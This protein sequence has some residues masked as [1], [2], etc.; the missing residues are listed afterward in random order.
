MTSTSV[1]EGR[2]VLAE[3]RARAKKEAAAE[4]SNIIALKPP[5]AGHDVL[6]AEQEE[7][8]PEWGEVEKAANAPGLEIQCLDGVKAKPIDWLW[9]NRIPVGKVSTLAGD[10]GQ[11]KST[12]LCDVMARTTGGS[13]W[14]D[15]AAG[16]KPASVMIL[17][18]EDGVEDTLVPRLMAAGADL[19]RVFVI[20]S[21]REQRDGDL[22]RRQFNLQA[23]LA[24]LD[25]EIINRGDI[26]LVVIDP[27]TS[28]LGQ[29]DSHKNAEVRAVV[30][31][32]GDLADRRK[33]AIL[34]NNHFSKGAGN[35]NS[36][37]IGSVAFVNQARAAFIVAPDAENDGRYFFMPSK[38][39][40]GPKG[41][42]LSY[43]IES[44]VVD[45]D[46]LTSRIAWESTPVTSTADQ[47][48][49]ALVGGDE[50]RNAR[51]EAE[52]FLRD[53]LADGPV[54]QKEMKA[55][56]EGNGFSWSTVKRA[57]AGVGAIAERQSIGFGGSGQW[58]WRLPDSTRGPPPPQGAHVSGVATLC[59]DGPL[60]EPPTAPDDLD[61]IPDFLMRTG[62]GR[63]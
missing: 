7:A 23:D 15:G 30:G 46:I 6:D 61:G 12:I 27:I 9:Y 16:D 18:A 54:S 22:T 60:V 51:A 49:A 41:D 13:P 48:L 57:K 8:A 29:V 55:A 47:V 5:V 17:A 35:A 36:R 38:A 4:G 31:P 33:V 63:Q 21:V 3:V 40:L 53:L 44:C 26:R 34:C 1:E 11:G 10:G 2:R 25:R 59:M 14:P 24:K 45:D 56:A 19:K 50:A 39:N 43:R 42:G 32:L 37:I 62:G 58:L 52:E 28:Y 20:R